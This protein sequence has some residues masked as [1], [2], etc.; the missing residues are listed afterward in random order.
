MKLGVCVGQVAVGVTEGSITVAVLSPVTIPDW[1]V[2]VAGGA[3]GVELAAAGGVAL[4]STCVV[5]TCAILVCGSP[6]VVS[7]AVLLESCSVR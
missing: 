3:V 6:T 2:A 1:L 7:V 5:L 4:A